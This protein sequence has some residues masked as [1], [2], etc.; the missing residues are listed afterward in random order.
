MG[1][2]GEL[3]AVEGRQNPARDDCQNQY[4]E[5]HLHQRKT[6][7]AMMRVI[8]AAHGQ[9]RP[10]VHPKSEEIMGKKQ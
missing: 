6:T 3:T 4:G 10:Q 2:I 1:L 5:K 7:G 8:Q 9:T